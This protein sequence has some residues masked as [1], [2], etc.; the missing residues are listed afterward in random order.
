MLIDS[1]AHLAGDKFDADRA[2]VLQRA[3]DAGLSHI[4][5]I[6]EVTAAARDVAR[7]DARLSFTTGVHPHEAHTFDAARDLPRIE[8]LVADGAVAIGECGLDY[9]YDHSPRDLQLRAF[10]LQLDLAANAGLPVVV[11]TRQAEEDTA[12]LVQSAA[13]RGVAGVLHCF[14]GSPELARVAIDAG[15][16]VSFSGIATFRTWERDDVV[17]FVPDAQLLVETDAPYLA[18][19]PHRGRRNESSFLPATVERIATVRGTT[20]EAIANLT[21][22]NAIRLFRLPVAI[23]PH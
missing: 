23:A 18:P 1:H 16:C 11:H 7:T 10:E 2:T 15:W 9:Y 14:T 13:K 21:A 6:G 19:V 8:S 4:V 22:A 17:T 20:A 12:R 5:I 3:W